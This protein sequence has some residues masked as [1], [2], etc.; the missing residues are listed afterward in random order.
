MTE[1]S[2]LIKGG[3]KLEGKIK[4]S[5]AKNASLK[6]IIAA[7]L[8]N[9]EVILKNIPRINDVDE[10]L[11]LIESLGAKARFMDK[12]TVSV[13]SRTLDKNRVD[14][15]YASKIRVSFMLFAPLLYKF[16]TCYVPNPGGCRIG[17]RPIDRIVEGMKHLGVNIDYDSNTGYYNAIIKDNPS[18]NYSFPKSSH[19]GTELLIMLSVLGKK[20]STINN[21]ALEPEIDELIRFLNQCGGK[22]KR[23]DKKITIDPA[24]TLKCKSHFE[25]ISDRNEAITFATLAIATIG[26]IIISPINPIEID[27]FLKKLKLAGGGVEILNKNEIRFHYKGILKSTNIETS[28]HPGF[29]TDWQPNWAI[30]MTQAKGDSIIYERVFENRFSY[31]EEL[32]KLGAQIDFIKI[33]IKNPTE[34]FFFNFNPN[35][36]Y[37]QAIRIKGQQKL[38]GGVLNVADLRAGATLAI[39]ALVADGESIVNNASI[40]ERGYENFVDKVS[41]LG[42]DITK[43]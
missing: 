8:L 9:Q 24:S 15:L 37:N 36:K 35:K 2:F 19:T 10:L 14:L 16:K 25:V 38:H 23:E 41:S 39:A 17:A 42:G 43:V 32:R 34:Y 30:L 11:H 5:G 20:R 22:I 26:N 13:D 21:A 31:V 12:N 1:D 33:P 29:M 3:K 40:I 6:I 7:L 27:S 18:G 4:L 28:P